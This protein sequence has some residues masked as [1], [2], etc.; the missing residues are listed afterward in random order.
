[1]LSK[2]TDLY[3][4]SF[5]PENKRLLTRLFYNKK[6]FEIQFFLLFFTFS[7][8]DNLIKLEKLVLVKFSEDATVVPRGTEWFGFYKLGKDY[9]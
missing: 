8:K 7:Y 1:M 5:V 9:Y 6:V 2:L 4:T 3:Q